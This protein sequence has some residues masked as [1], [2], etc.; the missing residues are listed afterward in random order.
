MSRHKL[1]A[2]TSRQLIHVLEHLGF[3]HRNLGAS[4]HQRYV[5]PDGRRTSVPVHQGKDIGR[6]LLCKILRG[7]HVTPD[8][9]LAL[10]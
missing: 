3:I 1:P 5:H 6:G 10:L 9:F 7:I 4:S 8:A 2:V